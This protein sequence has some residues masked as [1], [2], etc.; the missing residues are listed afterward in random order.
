MLT[1]YTQ[2]LK[3]LTK[4]SYE[5]H[6]RNHIK[7]AMGAIRLSA[8][9]T[10]E[11][12][13]LYNRLYKGNDELQGIAPKT[14]KNLHGVLHK[15]LGQ[16][17]EMGYIKF[18]PSDSCRLPRIEKAEIKPLEDDDITIFLKAIKGHRY[19]TLYLVDLFTGIRQGEILGLTW[20]C[21]DFQ[22]GTITI[23][24]QL[25]KI[26]GEY[27]FVSLKNDK[28]LFITPAYSIMRILQDHKKLQNEWRLKAGVIWE[29]SDL[30]FTNE[31]GVHLAHTNRIVIT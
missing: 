9:S 23:Y 16:A 24:R 19:E 30:V 28:R 7:P 11:I 22:N 12:Q 29:N 1:E 5:G 15:A 10:H 6:I 17:V 18:N 8:I 13:T 20:D 3:P 31:I 4:K 26:R 21:I 25:Q 27:K 14:L 2:N